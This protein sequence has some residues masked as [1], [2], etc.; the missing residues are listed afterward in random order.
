VPNVTHPA[1]HPTI[2]KIRI[3]NAGLRAHMV[4]CSHANCFV[5][6]QDPEG[7]TLVPKDSTVTCHS[8]DITL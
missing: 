8:E 4:G 1:L 7:G 6:T 2:A 3:E 5:T